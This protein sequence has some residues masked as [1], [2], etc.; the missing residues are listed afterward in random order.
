MTQVAAYRKQPAERKDYDL[1]YAEWLSWDPD[2]T[3]NDVFT[4]VFV[5]SGPAVE[6]LHVE[7]VDI[8]A[9]VAKLWISGGEHGATYKVE[10]TAHTQHGRVDQCEMKFTVK[11]A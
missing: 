8:T 5:V 4:H 9:T 7:R 6:P 3:L 2:D 11:D 1:D 10:I